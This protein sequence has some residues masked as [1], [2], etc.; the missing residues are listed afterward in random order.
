MIGFGI[1]HLAC[2]LIAA[3]GV[4]VAERRAASVA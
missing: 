4:R 1:G 2:T 3:H